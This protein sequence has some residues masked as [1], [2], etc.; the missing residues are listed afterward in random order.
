MD[1]LFRSSH[2]T[3]FPKAED[4]PKYSQREKQVLYGVNNPSASCYYYAKSPLIQE[5]LK[6][7]R[8]NKELL[9]I[10]DLKYLG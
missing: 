8:E 4:M 6:I 9:W 1:R 2:F 10:G 3:K 5:I 7:N